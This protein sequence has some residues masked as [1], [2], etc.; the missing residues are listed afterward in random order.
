MKKIL[1]VFLLFCIAS[2][3]KGDGS[4]YVFS[5]PELQNLF[6]GEEGSS[7]GGKS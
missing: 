4:L 6:S 5:P 7:K 2:V 3:V 1:A